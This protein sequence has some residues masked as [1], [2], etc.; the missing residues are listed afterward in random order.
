ME[1]ANEWRVCGNIVCKDFNQPGEHTEA[2]KFVCAG[3]KGMLSASNIY[4]GS[5]EREDMVH[6]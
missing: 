6:I 3:E 4:L 5:M 2:T 1:I